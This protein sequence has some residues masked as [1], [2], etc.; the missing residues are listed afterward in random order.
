[1]CNFSRICQALSQKDR[2][3]LPAC[4]PS[5]LVPRPCQKLLWSVLMKSRH[6]NGWVMRSHCI[7]SLYFPEIHSVEHLFAC[8]FA[9]C[10]SSLVNGL[11]KSFKLSFWFVITEFLRDL[12]IYFGYNSLIRYVVHN[13]FLQDWG[14]SFQSVFQKVD[15]L[16]CDVVRG[17]HFCSF[18]WGIPCCFREILVTIEAL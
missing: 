9:I 1:M 14:L 5:M 16:N 4:Q 12:K 18:T 15:I 8:L 2:T 3:F 17:T 11:F 10:V 6:S 13:Y 7:F